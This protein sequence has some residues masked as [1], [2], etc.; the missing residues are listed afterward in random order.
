MQLTE[1]YYQARRDAIAWLNSTRNFDA[2]LVILQNSGYKPLVAGKL[3]KWGDKPHSAEK[4]T[5]ELRQMIQVWGSPNDPIHEDVAFDDDDEQAI[6]DVVP[7]E[8]ALSII[9][10]G[11]ELKVAE[12][13]ENQLPDMM[14]RLIYLFSESYKARSILHKQLSDLPE[15][16]GEA[17]VTSRKAIITSISALSS[18]MNVLYA[19][20]TRYESEGV[21]PTEEELNTEYHDP[22]ND[23]DDEGPKNADDV[24][25]PDTV[26]ALKKMR[27]QEAPKLSR[28]KNMLE[29]QTESKPKDQKSNPLPD[30]P[31]RVKY[32]KKVAYITALIARIDYRIAELS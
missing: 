17:T 4:L 23:K 3:A 6:A 9:A 30:C 12:A 28:A 25:L 18:R 29:Y 8:A 10:T 5:H 24:L 2:G 26:D 22:D 14:K 13:D 16:N 21:L 32:E 31:K 11:E 15:D 20:R 7:E 1:T 27:K 19:L